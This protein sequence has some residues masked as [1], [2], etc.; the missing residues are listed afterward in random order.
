MNLC[1]ADPG[2]RTVL[3][4][5]NVINPYITIV[6]KNGIFEACGV[7]RREVDISPVVVIKRIKKCISRSSE[8]MSFILSDGKPDNR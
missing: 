3:A 7:N 6:I 8:K 5:Q 2:L 4:I 1:I